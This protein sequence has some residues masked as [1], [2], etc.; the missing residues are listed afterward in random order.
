MGDLRLSRLRSGEL[1]VGATA[2]ALLALMFLLPWYGPTRAGLSGTGTVN[3]F[4]GLTHLRWLLLV[5]IA[6]GLVLVFVQAT[7]PAPALPASMSVIVLVLAI[8]TSV[9]LIF[10]VLVDVPSFT[11]AKPA[12]Y[13]GLGLALAL[14]YGA[15]RSLREEDRPDPAREAAIPTV[16][17]R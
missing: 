16:R 3:G 12:A 6:A 14:T 1:I 17:L 15:Y 10:R 11:E 2:L 5:T 8:P 13:V 9:W 7:R 4:H